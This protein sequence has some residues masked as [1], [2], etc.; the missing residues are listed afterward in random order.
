MIVVVVT[1]GLICFGLS[2]F[3]LVGRGGVSADN[4]RDV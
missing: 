2:G 1:L 3:G 4:E